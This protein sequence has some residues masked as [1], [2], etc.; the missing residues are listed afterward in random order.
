MKIIQCVLLATVIG[1]TVAFPTPQEVKATAKTAENE[2]HV[3][4]VQKIEIH[5]EVKAMSPDIKMPAT[6]TVSEVHESSDSA[7]K[8]PV[9]VAKS[10]DTSKPTETVKLHKEVI[11]KSPTAD[12]SKTKSVDIKANVHVEKASEKLGEIKAASNVIDKAAEVT[13]KT[14]EAIEDVPE[15][16]S[17]F[18]PKPTANTL[19]PKPVTIEDSKTKSVELV[20]DT[21]TS[22]PKPVVVE[23]PLAKS[24]EQKPQNLVNKDESEKDSKQANDDDDSKEDNSSEESPK[25]LIRASPVVTLEE[26]V[27]ETMVKTVK[28]E[29]TTEARAVVTQKDTQVPV[30]TER[31]KQGAKS[32][33]DETVIPIVE[34]LPNKKP[35]VEAEPTYRMIPV[36][37]VIEKPKTKEIAVKAIEPI[38]PVEQKEEEKPV[39]KIIES[40][41]DDKKSVESESPKENIAVV[42]TVESETVKDEVK[43]ED[44]SSISPKSES[45]KQEEDMPL[46]KSTDQTTVNAEIQDS[47]VTEM[48][49]DD[50]V[51]TKSI[52]LTST[53]VDPVTVSVSPAATEEVLP[54]VSQEPDVF[55]VEP[56]ATVQEDAIETESSV[57]PAKETEIET[58]KSVEM[59][60]SSTKATIAESE[61]SEKEA[62]DSSISSSTATKALEDVTKLSEVMEKVEEP[63]AEEAEISTTTTTTTTTTTPAPKTEGK[64]G[65]KKLPANIRGYSKRL[66]QDQ[67]KAQ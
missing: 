64:K 37:V 47:T 65:K 56:V 19:E 48:Q 29:A 23:A 32:V 5:V 14:T 2:E 42:Q 54:K 58:V 62:D 27:K 34:D 15:S 26:A 41:T 10:S 20:Q 52:D 33:E 22:E 40:A 63:A 8:K 60:G 24:T 3:P 67:K 16:K 39:V 36:T 6:V 31:M 30:V 17:A 18:D 57:V 51:A 43:E 45:V 9:E 35:T 4:T 50:T 21:S 53:V 66:Q 49:K 13:P 46:V 55:I 7:L 59:E 44:S 11:V 12:E 28:E 25:E 1:V 38:K 61:T